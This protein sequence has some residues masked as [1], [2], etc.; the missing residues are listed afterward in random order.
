VS[1]PRAIYTPDPEFTQEARQAKYQGT[2]LMWVI[3]GPD[4]RPR[5]VKISRSLGMG[6]DQKAIEAVRRWRFE[7]ALKDG[8]PVAVQVNIEVNFH[9]Y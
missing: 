3:I 8:V 9:L 6:L 1:A 5:D 4:G 2:V 7:P